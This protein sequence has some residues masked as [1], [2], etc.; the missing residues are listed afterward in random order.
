[1]A[2]KGMLKTLAEEFARVQKYMLPNENQKSA[3]VEVRF[4]S[5]P[6]KY[7]FHFNPF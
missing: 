6:S 5:F 4:K 2:G 1:M 3:A 7:P